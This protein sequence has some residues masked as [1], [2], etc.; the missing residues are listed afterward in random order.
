MKGCLVS[1]LF[2]LLRLNPSNQQ[3]VRVVNEYL[4][5]IEEEMDV[6]AWSFSVAEFFTN[7][8][9]WPY[10]TSNTVL[11]LLRG[12]YIDM[13]DEYVAEYGGPIIQ[14]YDLK[15][16]AANTQPTTS[17]LEVMDYV[18]TLSSIIGL[19]FQNAWLSLYVN[20][21][22]RSP[23]NSTIP[24]V[25]SSD[26]ASIASNRLSLY[27]SGLVPPEIDLVLFFLSCPSASIACRA[28]HWY[29]R[30]KDSIITHNDPQDFIS[31]PIIF[32][33]GLSTDESCESWLLLVDVLIPRWHI[34][35]AEWRTR[36]VETFFGYGG[37]QGEDQAMM[38]QPAVCAG[39]G[40]EEKSLDCFD[41]G[42]TAN[43]AQ[44]DGLGWMEDV[45]NTVL[46][47][48]VREVHI[49]RDQGYWHELSRVMP[50]AYPQP[51]APNEPN[52]SLDPGDSVM[53]N[54]DG[55]E[56]PHD[57]ADLTLNGNE[58][59]L[60]ASGR[61]ML[62]VLALLVEAG[63]DLMPEELL[64]RLGNPPLLSDERLTH[65]VETLSRIRAILNHKLAR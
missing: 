21:R 4:G 17:I 6:T 59:R 63:A 39:V 64:D 43:I 60:E 11:C 31:F 18:V 62:G 34:M 49:V 12:R 50:E 32:S 42:V 55:E 46:R 10:G 1:I 36:F 52:S 38:D 23:H 22:T 44:A 14:E 45:W 27:N 24:T 7:Q 53:W 20:N 54:E 29:L 16:N 56:M 47:A 25:W 15:L 37:S 35:P 51:A 28:L 26:C 19:N 13:G 48:I 30:L 40:D 9:S 33:R 58:E 3:E 61:G 8:Q 57:G 41:V 5:I 2:M 65:D